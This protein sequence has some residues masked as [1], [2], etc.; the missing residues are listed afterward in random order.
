MVPTWLGS[1]GDAVAVSR[2]TTSKVLLGCYLCYSPTSTVRTEQVV[3]LRDVACCTA[4]AVG[5][6]IAGS[7]RVLGASWLLVVA[8]WAAAGSYVS[9]RNPHTSS[10]CGLTTP[11]VLLWCCSRVQRV[12]TVQRSCGADVVHQ[13]CVQPW[14]SGTVL[15]ESCGAAE[16]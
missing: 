16:L 13:I 14:C 1:A 5:Q 6:G 11:A 8:C 12:A 10:C 9:P 2:L 7:C 15:Q 3:G 4:A